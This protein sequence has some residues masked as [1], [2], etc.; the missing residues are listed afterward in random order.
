M[1]ALVLRV[2]PGLGQRGQVVDLDAHG[3]VGRV[4]LL[5]PVVEGQRPVVGI[6]GDGPA[7]VPGIGQAGGR[8]EVDETAQEALVLLG[9]TGQAEGEDPLPVGGGAV[10]EFL[11]GAPVALDLGDQERWVVE[12]LEVRDESQQVDGGTG[13]LRVVLV[14]AQG[15]QVAGGSPVRDVGGLREQPFDT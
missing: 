4:V 5:R 10:G 2:L 9:V 14:L 1:V 12:E 3:L 7:P 15:E 11:D 6:D 8:S 13:G